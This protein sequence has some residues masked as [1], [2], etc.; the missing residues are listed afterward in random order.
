MGASGSSKFPSAVT[1]VRSTMSREVGIFGTLQSTG[2]VFDY[3]LR[4]GL[5]YCNRYNIFPE[6]RAVGQSLRVSNSN[7]AHY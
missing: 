7:S 1:A 3:I 2:K 6:V 5:A 4:T